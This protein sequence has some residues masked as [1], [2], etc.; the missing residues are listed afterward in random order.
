MKELDEGSSA[1]GGDLYGSKTNEER[2]VGEPD[3][4]HRCFSGT[5]FHAS[6]GGAQRGG[7][8]IPGH[9][10]LFS[11]HVDRQ[12]HPHLSDIHHFYFAPAAV[13]SCEEAVRSLRDPGV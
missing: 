10:C 9:V 7:P 11:D 8:E 3:L 2:T 5:V 1:T 6:A 4:G 12:T 13:G